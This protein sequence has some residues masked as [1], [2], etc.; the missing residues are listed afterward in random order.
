VQQVS[1]EPLMVAFSIAQDR[2]M[3]EMLVEGCPVVIHILPEG[4]RTLMRHFAKGFKPESDPFEGLDL[5][6]GRQEAP[7]LRDVL[8]HIECRVVDRCEAG[9]HMVIFAEA[10]AAEVND[11][12]SRP[13][14]HVRTTGLGY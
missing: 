5:A 6:P 2:P 10:L 7:V 9:D 13:A 4:E 3:L 8:A 14:V 12:S 1:F 11:P